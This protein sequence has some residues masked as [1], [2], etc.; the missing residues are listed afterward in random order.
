METP[1]AES[2]Y[3]PVPGNHLSGPLKALEARLEELKV[4]VA[5]MPAEEHQDGQ[6]NW[7]SA[8]PAERHIWLP[9][10]LSTNTRF[11]VL[12]HEAAHIYQPPIVSH[13]RGAELFAELVG[14]R[15]AKHYGHDMT[16]SSGKYLA[17]YKEALI[18]EPVYRTDIERVFRILVG[19][20]DVWD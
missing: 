19:K 9:P 13:G 6:G 18:F 5:V 2:G 20:G 17:G 16:Q 3:A 1:F 14:W 10:M 4:T 8:V 15:V 12:A 7:G 11:E